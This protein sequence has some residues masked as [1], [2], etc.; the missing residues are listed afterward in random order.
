MPI[1]DPGYNSSWTV[2]RSGSFFA[3][4]PEL[5]SIGSSSRNSGVRPADDRGALRNSRDCN[6][7][8]ARARSAGGPFKSMPRASSVRPSWFKQK[9][10]CRNPAPQ[11]GAMRQSLRLRVERAL[12]RLANHQMMQAQLQNFRAILQRFGNGVEF[13]HGFAIHAKFRVAAGAAQLPFES[14]PAL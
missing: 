10:A 9:P 4:S 8:S 7:K 6:S 14:H 5:P 2:F 3:S 11:S 12:P 13:G 1:S